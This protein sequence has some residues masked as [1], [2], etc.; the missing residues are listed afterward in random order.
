ME[1]G[2]RAERL[3]SEERLKFQNPDKIVGDL[4]EIHGYTLEAGC[5]P[6]FFSI[7]IAKKLVGKGI[8]DA[9]DAD[10]H[11]IDVLV[12]R[13]E[14]I[15]KVVAAVVKPRVADIERTYFPDK[16]F[17]TIFVANVLHDFKDTRHFLIKSR[18]YIR[19]GGSFINIDWSPS[20]PEVG[21][22]VSLRIAEE[23]C[24]DLFERSGFKLSRKIYG[25][26]YHYGFVFVP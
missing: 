20:H 13:L 5:G 26:D 7:P 18:R 21:P 15:D 11:M 19:E 8:L 14:K 4:T 6:G 2:D 1:S 16:S 12:S 22:P 10:R 24:L 9:L 3:L 17:D 25:G 23:K